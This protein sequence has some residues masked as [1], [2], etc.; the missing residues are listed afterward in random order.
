AP[1]QGPGRDGPPGP[2]DGGR[3]GRQPPR[4]RAG[5]GRPRELI[6]EPREDLA[7]GVTPAMLSRTIGRA[8]STGAGRTGSTLM[9]FS[10]RRTRATYTGPEPSATR[11]SRTA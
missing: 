7:Q 3:G 2:R 11:S 4:C 6:P 5:V 10:E 8:T 9:P 1:D